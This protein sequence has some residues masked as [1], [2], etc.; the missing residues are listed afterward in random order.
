MVEPSVLGDARPD[1]AMILPLRNRSTGDVVGA[2]TLGL[3]PYRELDDEYGAFCL[4]VAGAVST[5]LT[6]ALAHE[7]QRHRAEELVARQHR[8]HR[9]HRRQQ[10]A[11][12]L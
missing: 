6:D 3:N 12:P 10:H 9:R 1:N 2:L 11:D 5:A 4:S 8:R 7:S